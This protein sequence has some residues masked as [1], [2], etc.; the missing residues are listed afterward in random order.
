MTRHLIYFADPMC[1]W[2]WGFAPVI[3]AVRERYRERLPVRLVLGGLAVG[4]TE[5]LDDR[6]RDMIREHWQHVAEL[7]GQPFDFRFFER[8]KFVYDT[9]PACRAVVAVRRL[10]AASAIDFLSHLHRGFYAENRDVTDRATLSALADEFGIARDRFAAEFD[11]EE[12]R[13]ET[14]ED[15][16]IAR[17]AG[18]QGYPTLLAGDDERGYAFITLGYQPWRRIAG[19]I[20]SWL[21]GGRRVS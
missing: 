6:G 2:C 16:K 7:T 19:V 10:A 15:F 3:Q 11:S 4:T 5:P 9:G 17:K 14:L 8:P 12:T 18:I 13:R 21:A 20:D 1:S